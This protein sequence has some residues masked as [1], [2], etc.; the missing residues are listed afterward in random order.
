ME[1]RRLSGSQSETAEDG[2]SHYMI[3]ATLFV[4]LAM[5]AFL[6]DAGRRLWPAEWQDER[7]TFSRGKYRGTLGKLDF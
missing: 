3:A 4:Y 7:A 6:N 5:E 1:R 2:A